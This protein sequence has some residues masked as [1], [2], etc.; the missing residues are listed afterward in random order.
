MHSYRSVLLSRLYT[1]IIVHVQRAQRSLVNLYI[2]MV[3]VL[4]VHVLHT[5]IYIYIYMY[6]TL[7]TA[8]CEIHCCTY[9]VQ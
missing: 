9:T 7:D 6:W 8:I 5:H 1:C 4:H 3:H 2:Y